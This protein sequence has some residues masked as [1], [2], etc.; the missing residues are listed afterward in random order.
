[1][2]R[3]EFVTRFF[4]AARWPANAQQSERMRRIGAL[5]G[6]I[7]ADDPEAKA[8]LAPSCSLLPGPPNP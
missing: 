5:D 3:R 6:G 4:S 1:M 8:S 2:Q 7:A